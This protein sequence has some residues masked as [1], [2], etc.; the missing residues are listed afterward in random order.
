[1][2]ILL[3]YLW[4][5][6]LHLH[7]RTM[8]PW[9]TTHWPS[10]CNKLLIRNLLHWKILSPPLP[11]QT[12]WTRLLWKPQKVCM[13]LI[14]KLCPLWTCHHTVVT[15]P[16]T[17]LCWLLL[18]AVSWSALHALLI[19]WLKA[20]TW[21][22][23]KILMPS[24]SCLA[25]VFAAVLLFHLSQPPNTLQN[26]GAISPICLMEF[27][28]IVPPSSLQI[29]LQYL[30]FKTHLV[31]ELSCIKYSSFV[32]WLISGKM[33]TSDVEMLAMWKNVLSEDE[34]LQVCKRHKTDHPPASRRNPRRPNQRD[35]EADQETSLVKML[36]RLV[37][38]H[39]DTLNVL[40]QQQQF[41]LHL[42]GGTGS[43]IPQM[44][45]SSMEWHQAKEKTQSLRLCLANLLFT[46]LMQRA[47]L[48]L[49]A[50]PEEEIFQNGMKNLLITEQHTFPYLTWCQKS[51]RL[52]LS[53]DKALEK[54]ELHKLLLNLTE[55]SACSDHILRFH[56]MKKAPVDQDVS[57]NSSFPWML[58]TSHTMF[59]VL[60]RLC[61]HSVWLL[62]AVDVKKQSLS[63]SPLA[64]QIDQQ[65]Q[66]RPWDVASILKVYSVGWMQLPW[67][68]AG[69]VWSV[70]VP[71]LAG[72]F[73]GFLMSWL[74]L[75]LNRWLWDKGIQHFTK[76]CV[77]GPSTIC[78]KDNRML[79]IS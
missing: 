53:K 76:C 33:E 49:Q 67:G 7:L 35:Q 60:Q 65:L 8:K 29:F 55:L 41:I 11:G 78:W 19:M 22:F 9:K 63:R 64:K 74:D 69:L 15:F 14:W 2:C 31:T 18:I 50:K 32:C 77:I 23:G 25:G 66:R 21:H 62:V 75:H 24:T 79:R 70:I 36:S 39:E 51:R 10:C 3:L 26:I 57:E 68:Y 54:E 73:H 30:G 40:M 45:K 42:K 20:T 44:M 27:I 34:L 28:L 48:L 37:I 52:I 5:R 6:I 12:P 72:A 56:A 13:R 16:W 43:L 58:T 17:T 38:R 61:Y 47:L 1:M 4:K 59:P 46:T 71:P